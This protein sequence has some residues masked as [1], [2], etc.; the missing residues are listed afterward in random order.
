MLQNKLKYKTCLGGLFSMLI[1]L[2][3]NRL[4]NVLDLLAHR[5]HPV[6]HPVDRAAI[7]YFIRPLGEIPRPVPQRRRHL[8]PGSLPGARRPDALGADRQFYQVKH[9]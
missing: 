8:G 3:L 1:G 9:W 7:K 2:P 5:Y 4:D 6:H